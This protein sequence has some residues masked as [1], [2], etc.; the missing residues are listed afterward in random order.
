MTQTLF[1]WLLISLVLLGALPVITAFI[2]FFLAGLHGLRNHYSQCAP[3][4][5]RVAFLIPAWNEGAVIGA[6]IERLLALNYPREHL[7]IYVVDDA[8]TDAT[9]HVVQQK[10]TAFAGT[11]FHL[12]RE[13]G[14]QGKAHTL[15]HGLEVVLAEPWAEAVMITDADVLFEPDALLRMTRHL[16]DPN[17]GAVT[18]YIK[19]GSV[20]GNFI[21][22]SVAFEYITAQAAARRAQNVLGV[23][24]CLAGGAQ[25]HS[26]ANL[27]AL[28]GKIDTT[29]L[30]E[31]TFT[32]FETELQGRR[33]VFDGHA[34][35]W[36]EEPGTVD[37][38]WKQRLR[39]ARGNLQLTM[40]FRHVWFRPSLRGSV[41]SPLFGVIWFS[42]VLMP[43]LMGI[44]MLA[45]VG[46]FLLNADWAWQIFRSFWFI[47]A[48]VYLFVTL[49]SFSIDPATAKRAWFQGIVFP[50]LISLAA[51]VFSFLPGVFNRYFAQRLQSH[52]GQFGWLDALMLFLYSW[53][54]LC[55]LA[56]WCVRELERAG[57]PPRLVQALLLVVGYGPLLCTI[58]LAAFIAEWRGL[59]R[60]WDKTEKSGSVQIRS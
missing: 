57:L 26:R 15:N 43:L 10:M 34:T 59:E 44:A 31:D 8:S 11:V 7:R 42:T 29:T 4:I 30:A 55:M 22:R 5:P 51:M 58:E 27:V 36:A 37:G 41:G 6:S 38:L 49:F 39:W 54:G 47:N 28:G 32:T 45:Q 14:G 21:T 35:V 50:G 48:G 25:L 18:A 12:R 24:A 53:V 9:P 46:L 3:Y 2:Q 17:T 40:A 56:A 20:P 13:R 23:M 19:E 52:T 60:K 1:E 33:V 16:A